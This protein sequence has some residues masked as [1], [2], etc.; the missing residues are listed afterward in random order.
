MGADSTLVNAA[1]KEAASRAGAKVPDLKPLYD[2]TV[3]IGKNAFQRITDAIK[4]RDTRNEKIRL[5]KESQLKRFKNVMERNYQSLFENEETMPQK[6]VDAIDERIRELQDEFEAV[7]TY[8]KNDTVENERARMR[9][10][11][12][13][14]RVINEAVNARATFGVL[15]N[16]IESWNHEEISP[17]IIAPQTMMMDL[18]NIDANDNVMVGFSDKGRLAFTAKNY[19]GDATSVWGDEVTYTIAQ[20][21]ENIPTKDTTVDGEIL[22]GN[23]KAKDK[24]NKDGQGDGAID[25][26][27]EVE[28]SNLLIDIKTDED[29]QNISRRRLEGFES[30]LSFKEALEKNIDIP[31]AVLNNMFVNID[32]EMM[33]VGSV[34]AE[35]DK[36]GPDGTPDG[37]INAEDSV[38]LEGKD[39]EAFVANYDNLID[40]LTNKDNDAFDL[41][42]SKSLLGDY[43]TDL[44]KQEYEKGFK[45]HRGQKALKAGE[46]WEGSY[47]ALPILNSKEYTDYDT[48]ILML[49]SMRA[50]EKGQKTYFGLKGDFFNYN[51][52]TKKW[53]TGIDNTKWNWE[54]GATTTQLIVKL[55]LSTSEFQ[56]MKGELPP[57]GTKKKKEKEKEKTKVPYPKRSITSSNFD[58]TGNSQYQ[59][60]SDLEETYK[61]YPG[62][63]FE[64][65][66][67]TL[68]VTAPDG[69]KKYI[70]MNRTLGGN[71]ESRD[72]IQAFI[73]KHAKTK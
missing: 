64:N 61:D 41:A 29:F 63:K 9:I 44:R 51:P 58:T 46:A 31:I 19:Y 24:G 8:G 30:T 7:N 52:D 10:N 11:G 26:D 70:S 23:Q 34:F 22:L 68:L 3:D 72:E 50:S 42:R 47:K 13:L 54:G 14:K 73:A 60:L 28:K 57:P 21:K 65:S 17:D 66:L 40:V 12:E 71:K 32:G 1:F 18:D 56:A 69:T 55:G 48:G 36:S 59:V 27:F 20:M 38:G 5:G 37:V 43:Y 39:L 62:F 25:F 4:A 35:L 15:R 33:D 45:Y 67:G 6:V 2:S 49:E 53:T 16:T